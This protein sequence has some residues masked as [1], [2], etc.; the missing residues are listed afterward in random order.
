MN[1]SDQDFREQFK[2]LAI[3][4]SYDRAMA[5]EDRILFS[6][7]SIGE[8]SIDEVMNK[9]EE[10]DPKNNTEKAHVSEILNS[11]YDKGLIKATDINNVRTFDL[12]KITQP[13]TGYVNPELL[14]PGLD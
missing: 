4:S 3:P 9:M 12:T 1:K 7:A 11:L 8:G 10:L 14:S 6:L 2:P 13:N 5:L